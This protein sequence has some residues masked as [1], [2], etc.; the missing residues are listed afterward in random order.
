[1]PPTKDAAGGTIAV[2][3]IKTKRIEV[4]LIGDSPLILN[5]MSLKAR[6]E[7][8]LPRGPKNAAQKQAELKHDPMAEFRA[9]PYTLAGDEAPTLLAMMASAVKGAM[10]TAALDL[11]IRQPRAS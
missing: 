11:P 9:S 10:M 2:Q 5:R 3:E 8:V 7:L 1:M 4:A 6:R